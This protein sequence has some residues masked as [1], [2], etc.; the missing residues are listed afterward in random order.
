MTLKRRFSI[1]VVALVAAPVVATLIVGWATYT[2]SR[3]NSELAGFLQSRRWIEDTIE[4]QL[5][6]GEIPPADPNAPARILVLRGER[7]IV[8]S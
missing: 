8:F 6:S 7:Q 3:Q 5:M 2:L 1:M 4:Q